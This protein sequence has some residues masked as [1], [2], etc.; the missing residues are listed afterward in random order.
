MAVL[1][2][3]CTSLSFSYD[4][5][6]MVTVNYTLVHDD[7][8]I[9]IS[10]SITAGGKTFSGYITDALMTAIPKATGWYETHVT[11]ISTTN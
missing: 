8:N 2:I 7:P 11:M 10:N 5:M 6:G 1:F 4:I 3:E 9:S